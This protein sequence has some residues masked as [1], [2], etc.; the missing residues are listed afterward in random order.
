MEQEHAAIARLF[1]PR[2]VVLVGASDRPDHWSRRV[3]DNLKRF[4][5]AGRIM[6]VNPNRSEIWG[7][8]CFPDVSVLPEAPDHLVL[9]TPAETS[10]RV[11]RDGAR[12]GAQSATLYA[13][14]FGEGDDQQGLAL[15]NELRA[16]LKETG[17]TIVGPNCMGVAC[18]KSSFCSIPDETLQEL[19]ESPVAIAAQSGAICA[20]LNRSINELGLKVSYFA[21]CG[22]QIGCKVS[23]FIDY[24]AVQPELKV[25]LCYIEGV[26][27]AAHFLAA[28]RRAYENG[29]TVLAIKIGA[30]EVAR[31]FALAHTGSLA[32]NIAAFEAV[33]AT[34]G[35]VRLVSIED[36]IEAVELGARCRPPRGPNIAAVTNSGALRNLI[37]EAADRTGATL[38]TLS[39]KTR[40]TLSEA[41]KQGDITNPLDTKRTIATSQYVACLDALVNAPEVDIV[42]TAEELPR[43]DGAER[44]V[45]NLR[46]LEAIAQRAAARGKPVA[47]FTPFITST[48]EY[49]RTVR[50]QIPSVPVM[51]DIDRTLRIMRALSQR[52]VRPERPPA[53]ES[54]FARILRQRAAGLDKPT[55][56][57]EVESKSLLRAYDIPLPQEYLVSLTEAI[58]AAHRIGFPVV[59]KGV[60]AAIPHKSEAG[61]VRLDCR[62]DEAVKAA[63][64]DL[65]EQ[66]ARLR[67]EQGRLGAA[68]DGILVAQQITGGVECVLGISRDPEMGP[69]VMFGLGGILVE[70]IKDVS[71]GAPGLERDEALAMVK[72]TRAARL[73]EGFRGSQPG[74]LAALLDALVNLGQ[75]AQDL[76]DVIEAIDINPFVVCERGAF[77][78]DGLVVL[79][80]PDAAA[81]SGPRRD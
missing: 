20:S 5:F 63:L 55:A 15:A 64:I 43:D 80:P 49:G 4:G 38:A 69:V 41:L 79:R 61:L 48:T 67:A 77:A 75:M 40:A 50:A 44:R 24:F 9:F 57:N 58:D 19:A 59:L 65:I 46:A 34:A 29:K 32:G 60:S 13:A 17:L 36:A 66:G 72:A 8:P 70:L 10:L 56:L 7:A 81:S 68:L 2:N 30:S 31:D 16:V 14:G 45:A 3:W 21:S 1:H 54:D 74:D 11:L 51:R 42:L 35:V 25:I 22:G 52:R 78:L 6:P 33:A 12:A 28:A 71:F 62:D 23:D 18:G 47:A 73:L 26:P 53:I 76:P 39:E 27:D 37:A